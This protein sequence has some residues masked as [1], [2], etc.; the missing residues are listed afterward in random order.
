MARQLEPIDVDRVFLYEENAD[1]GTAV[2]EYSPP[3]LTQDE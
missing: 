2:F 1:H 3:L